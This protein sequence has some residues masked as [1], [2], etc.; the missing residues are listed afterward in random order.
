MR[1]ASVHPGSGLSEERSA[2]TLPHANPR[3]AS[4]PTTNTHT[5]THT[6]THAHKQICRHPDTQYTY[7]HSV[8]RLACTPS[9]LTLRQTREKSHIIRV[10]MSAIKTQSTSQTKLGSWSPLLNLQKARCQWEFIF[11]RLEK[12]RKNF[13]HA[14]WERVAFALTAH[15]HTSQP[16]PGVQTRQRVSRNRYVCAV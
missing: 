12:W 1:K 11:F 5:H 4:E 2:T 9:L 6:H 3:Y 14:C 7:V 15:L 13:K 16:H 8:A 10:H